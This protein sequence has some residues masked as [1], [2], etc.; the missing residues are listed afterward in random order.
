MLKSSYFF[1]IFAFILVG[2]NSSFAQQEFEIDMGAGYANQVWFS[3]E[4]GLVKAE[5]KDNWDLAFEVPRAA[6]I[7][8]NSVM[9]AQLWH[10]PFESWNEVGEALDT[11]GMA[12]NWE[13]QYNSLVTWDI[14]AFNMG[15]DGNNQ[16]LDFGWGQYNFAFHQTEGSELFVL[17]TTNDEYKQVFI[18]LQTGDYYDIVYCDIDGSNLV[19]TRIDKENLPTKNFNYFSFSTGEAIDREPNTADWHLSFGQYL[20]FAPFG[21]GTFIPYALSGVQSNFGI[22]TLELQGVDPMTVDTPEFSIETFTDSITAIGSDWKQFE[23]QTGFVIP[24]DLVYFVADVRL[25]SAN[26][27][28][29]KVYFTA[30]GGSSTGKATMMV[31]GIPTSVIENGTDISGH[32][33][34]YPNIIDQGNNINLIINEFKSLESAVVSIVD[35]TGQEVYT[36]NIDNINGFSNFPLNSSN[37]SSGMYFVNLKT[38]NSVVT[39]KLIIK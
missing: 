34:I 27:T 1:V 36:R 12:D 8:I 26:P 21:D 4:T 17:K 28:M 37:L 13:E 16:T 32:F 24:E 9:G 6:G 30:F 29:Y 2:S 23:P 31:E 18:E 25:D 22:N 38:N 35:I 33:S 15:M 3:L 19:E 7:R 20:G 5:P 39:Q 10:V 11:T 14:G